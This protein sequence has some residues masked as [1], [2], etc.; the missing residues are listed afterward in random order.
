MLLKSAVI[1]LT[2]NVLWHTFLLDNVLMFM[3]L[4]VTSIAIFIAFSDAFYICFSGSN[5]SLGVGWNTFSIFVVDT[6]QSTPEIVTTYILSVFRERR[7]EMEKP[8][9]QDSIHQ[10]C[11]HFQVIKHI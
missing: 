5:H 3:S 2:Q 9:D 6:S 4:K 11:V 7:S 8:F 10:V 1:N